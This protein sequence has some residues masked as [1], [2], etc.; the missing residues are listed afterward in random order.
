MECYLKHMRSKKLTLIAI[1]FLLA[2]VLCAPSTMADDGDGIIVRGS[3][4]YVGL[5]YIQ[6]EVDSSLSEPLYFDLTCTGADGVKIELAK[7]V[8]WEPD[9]TDKAIGFDVTQPGI[10]EFTVYTIEN[11][12]PAHV[13]RGHSVQVF[14]QLDGAGSVLVAYAAVGEGETRTYTAPDAYYDAATG[15]DYDLAPGTTGV[16][17]AYGTSSVTLAYVSHR[18]AALQG[19]VSFVDTQGNIL[20]QNSFP[21][22]PENDEANPAIYPADGTTLPAT[23]EIDG[24]SYVKASEVQRV[25]A[26]YAG[27]LDYTILYKT[28]AENGAYTAVIHYVD[29]A[30]TLLLTDRV[31]VKDR[32][33]TYYAPTSFS[34]YDSATNTVLYYNTT[35]DQAK[36]VLQP[37][38]TTTVYEVAYT[39]FDGRS[40]YDWSIRLVD[41]GT[42]ALLG[43]QTIPVAANGSASFAPE[44]SVT[45]NGVNYVLDAAMQSSYTHNYGDV[46]RVQYV[47]YNPEG[48]TP[49]ASY[50]ITVQYKN[51]ADGSVLYT[52]AV[53]AHT[54]QETVVACPVNYAFG[55][56]D[57]IRLNGQSDTISHNFYSPKRTYTIYYR[58]VNDTQ[59]KDTTVTVTEVITSENLQETIVYRAGAAAADGAG[60]AAPPA[61]GQTL[62]TVDNETT[63]EN[64]LL[65]DDGTDIE[66]AREELADTEAPLAANSG[67]K[68]ERDLMPL[69]IGGG[70][71]TA[72]LVLLA[73]VIFVSRKKKKRPQ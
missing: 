5:D 11:G 21:V 8:L 53:A 20:Q 24:I 47:Y 15:A 9:P 33:I 43:T 72:A 49:P 56:A 57:Y 66:A 39:A 37:G 2:A 61:A 62:T 71:V 23:L 73:S 51:I 30:G 36:L 25:T 32:V 34:R 68:K 45:V 54:N 10:Y 18:Q 48:Y 29:Q 70:L 1:L 69:M 59:Y 31:A 67:E 19:T 64:T 55:G 26:S 60:A 44:T 46:S 50:N 22:L 63:G 40:G 6:F 12:E 28:K 27:R 16:S 3:E 4:E 13:T 38:S 7:K 42:N 14:H 52:E 17:I 41:G 65:T 58:D 35:A